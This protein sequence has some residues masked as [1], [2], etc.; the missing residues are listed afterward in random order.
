MPKFGRQFAS[1]P[2]Q[3]ERVLCLVEDGLSRR[4][5]ARE[6]FGDERSCGR[7]DR[8][9][10]RDPGGPIQP[11]ADRER[12]D[13]EYAAGALAG[14]DRHTAQARVLSRAAAARYPRLRF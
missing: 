9:V 2:E 3:R 11:V 8:I 4:A 1:T 7:V 13:M 6:V 14:E 12:T 10:R 5:A